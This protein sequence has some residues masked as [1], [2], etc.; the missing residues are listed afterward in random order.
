MIDIKNLQNCTW[1]VLDNEGFPVGTAFFA[2]ENML[3]TSLHAVED[4]MD[5]KFHVENRQENKI[6]VS[7]KDH[8]KENDLA[9]LITDEYV[10]KHIVILCSEE[11]LLKAEWSAF[12]FPATKEGLV[13]GSKLEGTIFDIISVKHTH[14]L[15]LETPGIKL[16]NE[17]SGFSGS[18]VINARQEITSVLRYKDVNNLCSVSIKKAENFLKKNGI[19]VIDDQLDDFSVYMP[20]AFDYAEEPLKSIG[21]AFAKQ[22]AKKTSPQAIASI[23]HGKLMTPELDGSLNKIIQ[24]LKNQVDVNNELW[25]AWLEFLSYVQMLKG[26]YGDINAVYISLPNTEVSKFIEGVETKIVQDIQLTLKFFFTEE[27]QYFSIAKQHLLDKSI[28]GTLQNNHCHIFHSHKT[29][30][31]L[32]PFTKEDKKNIVFDIYSQS[33]AGLNIAGN[34]DYGVLSFSQLALGIAASTTIAEATQNLTKIFN[35]AI[36]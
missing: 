17:Y 8:C 36:S 30:F 12:G 21:I 32:H 18:G 26:E 4:F 20:K 16:C 27:A 5:K 11:P 2:E 24:F 33:D 22:V 19:S 28:A 29:L 6:V 15:V 25:K 34:I 31:G 23:L 1:K 35:D 7:V 14:D 9:I 13:V 3:V 10:S